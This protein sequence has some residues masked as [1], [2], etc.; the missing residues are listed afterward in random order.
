MPE[1]ALKV[2][3]EHFELF[4]MAVV[5]QLAFD[6][7]CSENLYAEVREL[8]RGEW[9]DRFSSQFREGENPE[10]RVPS[11]R[12]DLESYL[13][14]VEESALLY[15]RLRAATEDNGVFVI[16]GTSSAISGAVEEMVQTVAARQIVET[17]DI[18]PVDPDASSRARLLIAALTWA[19]DELPALH[20]AAMADCG[21][22]VQRERQAS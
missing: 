12:I 5:R 10:D 11:N 1:I 13:R 2:P 17:V 21:E 16:K 8:E 6:V 18:S 4:T 19:L 7:Q 15:V 14:N 3:T 20:A 22:R 9:G